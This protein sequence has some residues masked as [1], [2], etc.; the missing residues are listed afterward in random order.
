[1]QIRRATERDIPEM[2]AMYDHARRIMA[3]SG[4]RGQ[5]NALYPGREE[6]VEDV[7][8]GNAYICEENGE[9][10]GTFALIVGEEPTYGYIED[11]QWG[12]DAV[13]GTIHRLASNGK[14]GG[15]AAACFAFCRER[16]PYLRADT[17]AD[18]RI[19][20]KLLERFGFRRCGIVYVHGHSPRIAYEYMASLL[21]GQK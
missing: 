2:L 14:A 13:Y 6:A 12:S 10:A 3:E 9:A 4:N 21:S 8:A 19:L 16:Q 7:A 18:N 5:W 1:M 15:V 20:Q 17:H 11:G